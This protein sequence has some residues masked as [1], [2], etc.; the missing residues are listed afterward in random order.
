MSFLSKARVEFNPAVKN[1]SWLKLLAGEFPTIAEALSGSGL[2]VNKADRVPPLT[3]MIYE[4]EGKLRFSLSNRE[5]PRSF[6]GHVGDPLH[7]LES[8][9]DAMVNDQGEWITKGAK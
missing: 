9:E 6:Y 1:E 7:V 3:L 4:K 8:I 5:Y 2:D